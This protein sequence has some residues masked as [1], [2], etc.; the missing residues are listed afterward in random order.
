MSLI[1][2][3]RR[4]RSTLYL[5]VITLPMCWS[6]GVN[7][8][9][10]VDYREPSPEIVEL[11]RAPW[12][13]VINVDPENKIVMQLGLNGLVPMER[14]ARDEIRL[15][16]LILNPETFAPNRP[17]YADRITL[18]RIED[19]LSM[20][21][22]GLPADPVILNVKWSPDGS[23]LALLIEEDKRVSLWKVDTRTAEAERWSDLRVHV[24]LSLKFFWASDSQS[25]WLKSVPQNLGDPPRASSVAEGPVVRVTR[26]KA[27]PTQTY[28]DLLKTAQDVK[29]FEYY[30]SSQITQVKLNGDYSHVG[31]PGLFQ[32]VQPSP[33]GKFLL[34]DRLVEP[35]SDMVTE[36]RFAYRWEV[37]T[38]VE[39]FLK[40]VASAPLGED[41]PSN[42]S[43]VRSGARDGR[44]RSDKPATLVWVE[45]QDGGDIQRNVKIRDILYCLEAPFIGQPKTLARLSKRLGNVIWHSEDLALLILIDMREREIH[46][47]RL[48][49]DSGNKTPR[50]LIT[51]RMGDRYKHSGYPLMTYN[52]NGLP[53]LQ[54]DDEAEHIYLI[55]EGGTQEGDRPF[56]VKFNLKTKK[57]KQIFRSSKPFYERPLRVLDA[58]WNQLLVKRE[59]AEMP[60]HYFIW[61]STEKFQR[62]V[63]RVSNPHTLLD[64]MQRRTIKY[65]RSDKLELTANLY[66][67]AGYDPAR[68]GPLPTFIWAY[69]KSYNDPGNAAQTKFSPHEFYESRWYKPA[70]W[71]TRG[72][73]VVDNPPM[74]IVGREN[75]SPNDN[76]ISQITLSAHALVNR[77]LRLGISEKGRIGI[78]GHSYGAFMAVNLLAHTDLFSA[79]I[80]R[81]GAYN[82]TLT[83]FGFQ[84]EDRILW[85]V[86]KV[87]LE[88]SPI[89]Q[90]QSIKEPL[91]LF[92]GLKDDNS[93]TFPMQSDRLFHA[94]QGLG[95]TA[96]LVLFP[97]E[98][99]SFRG[100]K[101]ILHMLWEMEQWL[102][103]YVKKDAINSG[104]NIVL[105]G[106]FP[107]IGEVWHVEQKEDDGEK[108]GE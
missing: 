104:Q 57:K 52:D 77:L 34:V 63:A 40:T 96:R 7:A 108:E 87:Y 93:G 97:H 74:P 59:S 6:N 78:G 102:D 107:A 86:P 67:P 16:G 76:F 33:D 85:Q 26:D 5:L 101:S 44:W 9:Q 56:L 36:D 55:G 10:D 98:A 60:P 13:P 2:R 79:G 70:I 88:M 92:H 43:A 80:A 53:I 94:I 24:G 91:L 83:P 21:V 72:Y 58:K 42:N 14:L 64:G 89:L 19:G 100:E 32:S 49:P 8:V 31:N 48:Y 95:G 12:L 1:Y 84:N 69:P 90:A 68:D 46:F 106:D 105:Q 4:T 17:M 30:F 20:P 71:V 47:D 18:A 66:L 3:R 82:R 41:M 35:W 81:N 103:L 61:N 45:A 65:K 62:S 11:V 23:W 29:K 15:A 54:T 27:L 50:R 39:G 99:H 25:V 51:N 75:A 38:V 28:Q 22:T 73:A 37:W